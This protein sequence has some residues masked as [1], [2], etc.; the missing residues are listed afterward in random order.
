MIAASEAYIL[1]EVNAIILFTVILAFIA[2][3]VSAVIMYFVLS[4]TTKPIVSVADTLKIVAEGN[5]TQTIHVNTKDE[6]SDLA[7][8]FN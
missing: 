7:H 6:L 2:I 4:E 3:A 5:L 8:D 1:K